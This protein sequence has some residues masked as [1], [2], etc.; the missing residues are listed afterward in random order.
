MDKSRSIYGQIKEH[1]WTNQ[2]AYMDKSRSIY[3]QNSNLMS[4][5]I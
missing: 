1:I 5:E 3:G 2:G 4:I